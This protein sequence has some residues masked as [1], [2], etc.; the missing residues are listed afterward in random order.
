MSQVQR[1]LM[2]LRS[3]VLDGGAEP[4]ERM[5]EPQL[6]LKLGLSRTPLRAAIAQLVEEGLLERLPGGGCRVRALKVQDVIDAI[7]LRGLYEGAAARRAAE[8]GTSSHDLAEC[9]V[10]AER[11]DDA[12]GP[13]ADAIDFDRYA[14]LNEEFHRAVVNLCGSETIIR[15]YERIISLPMAGPSSFLQAQSQMAEIRL[16]LFQA[17]AQHRAL[18][19]AIEQRE[20]SRAEALAREHARLARH[21]LRD[22]LTARPSLRDTVPGLAL[23][24]GQH[25][26]TPAIQSQPGRKL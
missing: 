18:L 12:L 16:S 10:I 1:A 17:H 26:E 2:G 15:E 13:N 9:H 5:S 7:E 20:G 21:N 4:G 24:T 22:V 11:I 19:E 3:I 25:D 14:E 6:A 8:A 23:V